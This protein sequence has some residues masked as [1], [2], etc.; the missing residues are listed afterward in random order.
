MAEW[1]QRL[2]MDKRHSVPS[3]V[4]PRMLGVR[5][6]SLGAVLR[7]RAASRRHRASNVRTIA[8][9]THLALTWSW[10]CLLRSLRLMYRTAVHREN[11]HFNR[12]RTQKREAQV[13]KSKKAGSISVTD[14]IGQ[15]RKSISCFSRCRHRRRRPCLPVLGH[16]PDGVQPTSGTTGAPLRGALAAR[17]PTNLHHHLDV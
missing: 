17:A 8:A 6:V 11:A 1:L 10:T 12:T 15:T 13:I 14:K 9:T 7:A 3:F 4:E 2:A 16:G 5:R